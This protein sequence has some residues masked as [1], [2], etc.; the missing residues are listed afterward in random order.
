M[1][2]RAHAR[3]TRCVG[4]ESGSHILRGPHGQ[5]LQVLGK[6]C[7]AGSHLALSLGIINQMHQIYQTGIDYAFHKNVRLQCQPM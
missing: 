5:Q 7:D 2:D 4:M 6:H 3:V 1:E